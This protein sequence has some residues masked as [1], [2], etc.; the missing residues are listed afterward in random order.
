[1]FD[2]NDLRASRSSAAEAMT[3]AA[4]RITSLEAAETPDEAAIAEAQSEFDTAQA[5]FDKADRAVKRAEAVEN[6]QAA[7]AQSGDEGSNV[8]GGSTPAVALDPNDKAIEVGFIVSALANQKGN[9]DKAATQLEDA[10]HTGVAA[11]LSGASDAA[12]G[13]MIPE[14][15]AQKVI[16]L[17]R[18]KV[19]VRKA[20]AES[21]PIPAGQMRH[22]RMASGASA[23]YGAEAAPAVESEPTFDNVD[24]AFRT[25]TALVP[26]SR[27]LIRHSSP[28]VARVARNDLVKQ[29]AAREDIAFLRNDGTNGTPKGLRH[30]CLG[31]NWLTEAAKTPDAVEAL[32]S[33]LVDRV[34]DADVPML[35]P[36]WAMRATTKNFLADLRDANGHKVY[37]TIDKDGTLKGF[38]IHASSQIPNNLGAGSNE[39]EITFADFS[40]IMIGDSMNL[41]IDTSNEATFVNQS[42][43]TVSAFQR[44]LTLMRAIS[45]HDLAPMHDE[46]ISGATVTD[47]TL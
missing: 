10:G 44:D 47:W 19:I 21:S 29:M 2:I 41:M 8:G 11:I 5:D 16:D 9:L 23:T 28:A 46:A 42:G 3:A 43:D 1:M 34:E 45:E 40:E 31:P 7:A 20:G 30:W 38:K 35:K 18:P 32:I 26:M 25:L 12:G 22:A 24:L 36:G 17:L 4:N 39:T 27:A 15:L 13:V 33:R 37:P 14:P 6:A